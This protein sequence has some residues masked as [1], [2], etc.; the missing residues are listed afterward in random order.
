MG[1]P[2]NKLEINIHCVSEFWFDWE[3]LSR[4]GGRGWAWFLKPTSN[5]HTHAQTQDNVQTWDTYL[6][7]YMCLH[8]WI[9]RENAIISEESKIT[10]FQL[11]VELWVKF[12]WIYGEHFLSHNI[13]LF[14]VISC[15]FFFPCHFLGDR[16]LHQ[17]KR[18]QVSH[19]DTVSALNLHSSSIWACNRM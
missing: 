5:L 8:M 17:L 18:M 13:P 19:N 10:S 16:V 15:F 1:E 6:Y 11:A 2:Q 12:L 4:W 3:S 14:L 9:T 7:T